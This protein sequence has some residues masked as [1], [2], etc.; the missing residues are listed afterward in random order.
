MRQFAETLIGPIRETVLE[1]AGNGDRADLSSLTDP[2]AL[3]SAFVESARRWR[4]D[5]RLEVHAVRIPWE[6]QVTGLWLERECS[7]AVIVERH[8]DPIHRSQILGHELWHIHQ[9]DGF[10][11]EQ[12]AVG[13][14][15]FLGPESAP[16]VQTAAARSRFDKDPEREAETFGILVGQQ[17][18]SLMEWDVITGETARNIAAALNY[19]GRRR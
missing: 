3:F 18:R 14:C 7:D 1:C 11:A 10:T 4:G 5:R 19:Q 15:Q 17:L 6:F 2:E 8:T 13:S 9:G 16:D 12:L